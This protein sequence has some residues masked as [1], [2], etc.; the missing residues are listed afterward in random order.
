MGPYAADKIWSMVFK[1]KMPTETLEQNK[2]PASFPK[3]DWGNPNGLLGSSWT[4]S[5]VEKMS[6]KLL[7]LTAFNHL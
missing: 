7:Y 4:F 2:R 5:C 3:S 6:G 1:W